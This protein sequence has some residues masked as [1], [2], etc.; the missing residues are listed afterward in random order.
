MS[1]DCCA[2]LARAAALPLGGTATRAEHW[3]LLEVGGRWGSDV[4]PE[5]DLPARA[6]E[7][8]ED[9]LA[10]A[11]RSRVLFVRRPGREDADGHVVFVLHSSERGGWGRRIRLSSYDELATTALDTGGDALD[12]PLV[13]V[14][15]HGRR[16]ACCARLGVP[17][18]DALRDHLPAE[19]LWQSSHQGGHRHA[20]NVLVLPAGVQLGRV[21]PGEAARV[22]AAILSGRIPLD[23][24]RGRSLYEPLAQAADAAVRLA[25]GKD[26]L[27][28]V[29]LRG[30]ADGRVRLEVAGERIEVD[31]AEVPGPALP[32]SCGAE[33]E[34]SSQLVVRGIVGG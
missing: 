12:G 22:A 26:G 4:L 20:A 23:R 21:E 33:P 13:L 9:W 17:V 14:C 15:T 2:D 11:P 25:S 10:S 32:P 5:S 29:R 30:V 1:S 6:R 34:P 19:Q 27:G 18:Y 24:Y 8:I 16:D 31:V 28:D 7:R 3:L